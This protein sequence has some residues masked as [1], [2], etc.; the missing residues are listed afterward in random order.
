MNTVHLY[1]ILQVT[2]QVR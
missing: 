2:V 1:S